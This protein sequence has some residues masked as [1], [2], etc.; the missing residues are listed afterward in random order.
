[1][2]KAKSLFSLSTQMNSDQTIQRSSLNQCVWKRLEDWVSWIHEDVH[3]IVPSVIKNKKQ[4][5]TEHQL[6]CH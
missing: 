5:G 1:M 3:L 4:V 2:C 6:A